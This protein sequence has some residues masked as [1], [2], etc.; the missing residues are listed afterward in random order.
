MISFNQYIDCVCKKSRATSK[1][2]WKVV[3]T[4][5][6]SLSSCEADTAFIGLVKWW[7]LF[8]RSTLFL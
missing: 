6:R 7:P 4:G 2:L 8:I 1:L 3:S 5:L